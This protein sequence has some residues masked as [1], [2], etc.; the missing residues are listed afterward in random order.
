[1][2]GYALAVVII[3]TWSPFNFTL[4]AS[5]GFAKA[6]VSP[7]T[8]ANVLFF[9]P[10]GF[11][12]WLSFTGPVWK[13]LAKA[14]AFGFVVSLVLELGQFFLRERATELADLLANSVGALLGA[15]LC[16]A[17][18][19][20]VARKIPAVLALEHPLT[21][22]LYLIWPLQWL[23]ALGNGGHSPR[24]ALL[25]PLG[26]AGAVILSALW[27]F[28][29]HEVIG[30]KGVCAAAL[31]WFAIGAGASAYTSPA[32]VIA[33]AAPIIGLTWFLTR[34]RRTPPMRDAL[35]HTHSF[36]RVEGPAVRA[37][38]ILL[39]IYAMMTASAPPG[40][41]IMP[42]D[43]TWGYP[44]R[45][46]GRDSAIRFTEQLAVLTVLGYTVAQ[47]LGRIRLRRRQ[48]VGLAVLVCLI[49]VVVL[50]LIHGVQVND[51]ASVLRGLASGCAA[52]VG[53]A[54]YQV[55]LDV[56][57]I[58]RDAPAVWQKKN[59]SNC[60]ELNLRRHAVRP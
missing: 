11:V 25:V 27:H 60:S 6:L 42:F 23:V 37:V 54:L 16:R 19:S 58:L 50:E 4:H 8:A 24:V 57:R 52:A 43:L 13:N 32:S 2:L 21:N 36:Q 49:I 15:I 35:I 14:F 1:M 30:R 41:V 55:Q 39:L 46:F 26:C 45:W 40:G 20:R 44:Q 51:R 56:V 12:L 47:A 31:G 9:I 17:V 10:L 18:T 34:S 33:C 53:I 29:L 3:L 28:R 59:V 38:G 7:D 48:M 22:L 5:T